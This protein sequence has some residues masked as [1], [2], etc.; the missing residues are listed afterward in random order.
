MRGGGRLPAYLLLVGLGSG[1]AG[2][3]HGRYGVASLSVEGSDA[4]DARAIEACL[5]TRE[6]DTFGLTL[7]LSSPTCGVPPFTGTSPTLRLWRWP[8]TEWPTFNQAVLDRDIERV[9]RFYRARGYYEAKVVSVTVEPRE[10]QRPGAVGTCDPNHEKCKVA[11]RIGVEEG[12]PTRVSSL[13][14]EGIAAL[15][16][17][18]RAV[19]LA[20]LPLERGDVVDEALYEQG[21]AKLQE[22]L[23]GAGYASAK[24]TGRVEVSTASESARLTYRVEAGPLYHYGRVTI[25][26]EGARAEAVMLAA[27]ELRAGQRYDPQRLKEAQGELFAMGSFSA[28]ELH[29]ELDPAR[30]AVDVRIEVSPLPRDAFRV[31]VGVTSGALQRTETSELASIPQWDGHVA[32]SYERRHLLGTLA[33]IRLEERPRIIFN[34]DFPRVETPRLGNIVRSTLTYPGLLEART[35]SFVEAAWDYGPEPF[36]QFLRSDVY[37]RLGARR[38]FWQRK[39]SVTLGAQQ[40]VFLVDPSP[41]NVSSDGEPKTSYNF[42]F[43]EQDV[44][45][46]LRDNRV[47]PRRGAYLGLNMSEALRWPGS[48][49]TAFRVSPEARGYVPLPWDVVW[50]TRLSLAA[51]FITSA[52]ARQTDESARLGPTTYRLRGGGANSNRGFLAGTLGAGY[53]GGVRRWEASTE[54]RIPVGGS[55]VLAGF[56]DLGDVNDA[57]SVRLEHLN[58]S[59]GHGFRFYTVLGAI[60]LD[61]GYRLA[62]LQRADSSAVA[63]PV[64]ERLPLIDVPGAVH[65]TIGDAF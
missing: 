51:L 28:V 34:R 49:W 17:E 63:S 2:V 38:A 58:A 60:R 65:L 35:E 6:R 25:V 3:E 36:L 21:K 33:R 32:A 10:A 27:A 39:L 62:A 16:R 31:M 50:A 13:Q 19:A 57:E 59:V 56:F 47:R 55:F 48:D 20:T 5:I 22:L 26:G 53:G 54:L 41:D 23:R 43:L 24:V 7:G 15:P 18:L 44:R 40:D 8:W 12:K 45:L 64:T 14:V 52:S 9:Q 46:D 37:A 30:A 1:C 11:L 29:E 61:V 4:I 42:S